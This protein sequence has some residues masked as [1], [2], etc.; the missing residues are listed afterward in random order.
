[1]ELQAQ[2]TKDDLNAFLKTCDKKYVKKIGYPAL[3]KAARIAISEIKKEYK[4]S[5]KGF[6]SSNNK[7]IPKSLKVRK[8][9]KEVSVWVG[10]DYYV[11][12][13]INTGTKERYT[14]KKNFYR[15]SIAGSDFFG[16][17]FRTAQSRM[18][19]VIDQEII[20][21]IDKTVKNLSKS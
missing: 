3:T 17:G 8:S 6:S 20:K 21:N 10:T 1:M 19:E 11:A 14:K 15:G 4:L 16:K 12:R 2:I 18:V 7:N 5:A 13:F 9:K